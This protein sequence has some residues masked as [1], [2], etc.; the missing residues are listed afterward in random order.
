MPAH[1]AAVRRTRGFTPAIRAATAVALL[2]AL[3]V[4]AAVMPP[5]GGSGEARP[6]RL[7]PP[8]ALASGPGSPRIVGGTEVPAGTY[9][10]MAYLKIGPYRCGGSLIDATHILTA[11]HCVTGASAAS[12]TAYIGGTTMSGGIPVGSISRA[13]SAV[14]MHP[15]YNASTDERDVAVITLDQAVPAAADGGIDPIGFV[16][17][18]STQGLAEGTLL[19]VAGWGT[20]S[21]GGPTSG[22]L[23]EVAVPA[24]TDA[25]C[26]Q[27]Y[28]LSADES[29]VMF[30]A[31][32]K[33][34]GQDS[35]QGDSGGPLFYLDTSVYTQVGIVSWGNGCAWEGYPGVYSRIAAASI[36]AFVAGFVPS[37]P[38]PTATPTAIPT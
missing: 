9:R 33:T 29:A 35:C 15:Q 26:R 20:T 25:Y 31:G 38:A 23:L 6:P 16:A 4:L 10:F 30:C 7:A 21:Y 37:L 19:T 2:A 11:A 13:A 17:S 22:K 3:A 8:L 32:P 28:G 27:R 5:G 14:A 12:I 36:N 24:Q 18:G 1:A 34:G